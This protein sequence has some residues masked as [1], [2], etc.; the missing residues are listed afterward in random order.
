MRQEVIPYE[1]AHKHEVIDYALHVVAERHLHFAETEVQLFPDQLQPQHLEVNVNGIWGLLVQ[2]L[3]LHRVLQAACHK[4]VAGAVTDCAALL[5]SW[6]YRLADDVKLGLVGHQPQHNEVSICSIQ[7][8]G[9]VGLVVG[10]GSLLPDELH[11]LV[12]ALSGTVGITKHYRHALPVG[13]LIHSILHIVAQGKRHIGQKLCSRRDHIR[14]EALPI[15]VI[16]DFL[17]P[18]TVAHVLIPQLLLAFFILQA[19]SGSSEAPRAL[20][21]HLC[22]RCDSIDRQVQQLP[23][24]YDRHQLVEILKDVFALFLKVGRQTNIMLWLRVAAGMDEPVHIDIKVVD[25]GI[26][27]VTRVVFRLHTVQHHLGVA[28]GEPAEEGRHS[29]S[30]INKRSRA[31]PFNS[32]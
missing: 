29:H 10:T 24:P 8:M 15:Y 18:H 20:L 22:P 19:F 2:K 26:E 28:H 11:D 32:V 9:L 23:W 31:G 5:V 13:M 1:E 27:A 4:E 3:C 30:T 14:I 12:L 16:L 17:G 21:V 6:H 7:A 25:H